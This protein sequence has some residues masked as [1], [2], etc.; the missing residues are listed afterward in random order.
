MDDKK[1]QQLKCEY[2]RC[3]K[4][5]DHRHALKLVNEENASVELPFCKYHFYIMIGGHFEARIDHA[6]QNLLGETKPMSFELLGPMLE[7]EIAEQVMGAREM[8]A[9]QTAQEVKEKLKS[10][11]KTLNQENN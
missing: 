5:G 7:V 10:D 3:K 6:A 9:A 2:P 11:S 8:V 1:F 4:E